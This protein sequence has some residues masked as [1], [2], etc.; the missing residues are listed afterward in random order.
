MEEVPPLAELLPVQSAAKGKVH[1]GLPLLHGDLFISSWPAPVE[2]L[3]FAECNAWRTAYEKVRPLTLDELK[4]APA[5]V[6]SGEVPDTTIGCWGGEVEA[7]SSP[8]PCGLRNCHDARRAINLVHI[9]CAHQRSSNYL[10]VLESGACTECVRRHI[11][12][13]VPMSR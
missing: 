2:I 8:Q 5:A 4:C 11:L 12:P 13:L 7:E 3:Q 6:V 1:R 10:H 9:I